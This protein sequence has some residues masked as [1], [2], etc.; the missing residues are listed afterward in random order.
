MADYPPPDYKLP[1]FNSI[2]YQQ[3]V[4]ETIF[5]TPPVS[6]GITVYKP[7]N[8]LHTYTN[9]TFNSATNL[10]TT[11]AINASSITTTS[12][13][14]TS[15]IVN[16]SGATTLDTGCQFD[17][18]V[19]NTLG[20]VD[21]YGLSIR[22]TLSP[23]NSTSWCH[24][25]YLRTV[26]DTSTTNIDTYYNLTSALPTITGPGT[27]TNAYQGYFPAPTLGTT[28]NCA[29]YTENLSIGYATSPPALGAIINGNVG[30]GTNSPLAKFHVV[31]VG[32]GDTIR[33]EDQASDTSMFRIDTSGRAGFGVTSSSITAAMQLV[34]G[35]TGNLFQAQKGTLE[36]VIDTT[37]NMC[38]NNTIGNA[39]PASAMLSIISTTK[40]FL[41][42]VM[43]TTQKNAVATPTKGLILFDSV[44]NKLCVYS[45]T[46]WETITSV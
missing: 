13:A 18:Q 19:K 39:L 40:G 43:T 17:Y 16:L 38:I 42:P 8:L 14:E 41:P 12:L 7:D 26:L 10:L 30:I 28:V 37:M 1:I 5:A 24:N 3:T 25:V 35:G 2:D 33:V 46:A 31:Q 22:P 4:D 27:C 29:L 36:V 20:G 15:Y 45:G 9:L 34:T 6:N 32:A 21:T 23:F 11:K 44:L